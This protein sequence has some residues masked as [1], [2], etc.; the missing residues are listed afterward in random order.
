MKNDDRAHHKQDAVATTKGL[1]TTTSNRLVNRNVG[2][3]IDGM[4]VAAKLPDILF[5][6]FVVSIN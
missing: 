4:F 5:L 2:P 1:L 6:F 3:L